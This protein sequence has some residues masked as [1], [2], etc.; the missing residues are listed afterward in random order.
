MVFELFSGR[1]T[2]MGATVVKLKPGVFTQHIY[3]CYVYGDVWS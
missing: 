2:A 1:D 3:V